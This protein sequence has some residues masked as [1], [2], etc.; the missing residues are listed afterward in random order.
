MPKGEDP[1][2]LVRQK[3]K[4]DFEK[5]VTNARDFFD[6][7]IDKEVSSA[8]ISS[9]GAKIDIVRRLAQT[10]SRVHDPLMRGEVVSKASAR[11]GVSRADFESA[12]PK[13]DPHR[14]SASASSSQGEAR[15]RQRSGEGATPPSHDIAMLCLLALRD[16]DARN[17]LREQN[18]HDVLAQTPNAELLGKILE[19]D[20]RPDDGASLNAFMSQLDAGEEAVVSAWLLQKMPAE[21]LHVAQE[22]WRGLR[23]AAVRRQLEVAESRMKLPQ[24]SGGEVTNLQKQILDLRE[25]LHELSAVSPAPSFATSSEVISE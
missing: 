13:V 7:W 21:P 10:I 6:Y 24:I 9:M 8:D 25:Q 20:L 16:E 5:R 14:R 4:E 2:S 12:I 19:S 22:W 15:S 17:F 18:F 1:D 23:R 11:L 3:G